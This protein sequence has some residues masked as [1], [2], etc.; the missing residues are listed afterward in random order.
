MSSRYWIHYDRGKNCVSER[1]LTQH[2][3]Q[4]PGTTM[5]TLQQALR[6]HIFLQHHYMNGHWYCSLCTQILD[7]KLGLQKHNQQ[8]HRYCTTAHLLKAIQCLDRSCTRTFASHAD[9][10]LHSESGACSPGAIREIVNHTVAAND[11]N[12]LPNN[13]RRLIQGNGSACALR[14]PVAKWAMQA[15]WNASSFKCVLSHRTFPKLP[16]LNA[17]LQSA[18]HDEPMYRCLMA[19]EGCTAQFQTL[20]AISHHIENSKSGVRRF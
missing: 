1:S 12:R 3:V 14:G 10:V 2:Y 8:S 6:L 11:H 18:A 7:S 13:A 19:L 15:S 17:H 9:L 16:H 5:P 20:S 4:S